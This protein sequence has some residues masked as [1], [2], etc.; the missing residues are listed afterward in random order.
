MNDLA[1]NNNM[2]L[3]YGLT[4]MMSKIRRKK[5]ICFGRSDSFHAFFRMLNSFQLDNQIIC[6]V[7]NDRKYWGTFVPGYDKKWEVCSPSIIYTISEPINIVITVGSV[8]TATEIAYQL[9]NMTSSKMNEVLYFSNAFNEWMLTKKNSVNIPYD[10]RI[11]LEQKIPKKIHYCWFGKNPIPTKYKEWM[12]TWQVL[13]PEYE[14][15]KWDESNYDVKKNKYIEDAYKAN[16]YSFVSDFARL[17]IV[18]HQGGIY[19]DT[20]IELIKPL[21]DFLYEYGFAGYLP[22]ERIATGLGFGAV[23][24]LPI[25]GELMHDY[26][27]RVFT[28]I[29]SKSDKIACQLC[30]EIQTEHLLRNKKWKYTNGVVDMDGLRVYPSP[31]FDGLNADDEDREKYSYSIHHYAGS[32]II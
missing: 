28:D 19:L 12:R 18:F 7:D 23:P 20:D 22:D 24:R 27:N 17:D 1:M 26:D 5:V 14:I 3:N 6:I 4:E 31:V 13:C 25:I 16:K 11:F 10:K 2:Y 8:K 15:I 29:K 21:D 9:H 32:W 30:S